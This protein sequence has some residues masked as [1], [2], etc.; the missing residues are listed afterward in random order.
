MSQYILPI[1]IISILLYGLLKRKNIYNAF[2][3]GSKSSFDLVLTS[4]PYI[5]A[6]FVAVEVFNVS[7]LSMV[8][9][10]F[11]SPV[12]EFFGV[13]KELSQLV[14]LKN[15]TGCGS[16]ALLEDIFAT[17]G[18]DSYL[19]RAGCCIA[20]CSEAIF[21]ITAVYFSKTKVTKFRYAIPVGVLANFVGAMVSCLI[22]KII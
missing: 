18:V 21:Y 1:M 16:L 8:F 15:F 3:V 20:G 12:F 13:P 22:C 7:G 14:I 17:Y 10:D 2:V 9:A 11:V 6:I 19:A 5:V 4:L